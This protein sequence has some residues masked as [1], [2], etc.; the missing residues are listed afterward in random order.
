MINHASTGLALTL[1]GALFALPAAAFDFAGGG[2]VTGYSQECNPSNPSISSRINMPRVI[3]VPGELNGGV[4]IVGLNFTDGTLAFSSDQNFEPG[5]S[6]NRATV[7]FTGSFN[8]ATQPRPRIRTVQRTVT[9]PSGASLEDADQVFLRLIVRN[10]Y[11]ISGCEA[12]IVATL[13]SADG[14]FS[15]TALSAAPDSQADTM[16]GSGALD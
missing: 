15:E 7:R 4:N 13:S 10:Y 1:A 14:A 6:F 3:Y 9:S 2:F 5:R 16:T 11:G 12:T 8:Y